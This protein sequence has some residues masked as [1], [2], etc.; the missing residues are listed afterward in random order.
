MIKALVGK[1][2]GTLLKKVCFGKIF[3]TKTEGRKNFL[4]SINGEGPIKR[5]A[6]GKN[7]NHLI[8]LLLFIYFVQFIYTQVANRRGALINFHFF[9]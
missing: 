6:G 4:N 1:L 7:K 3:G 5:G 9:P 8:F 2:K